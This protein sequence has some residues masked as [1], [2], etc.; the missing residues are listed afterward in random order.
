MKRMIFVILGLVFQ[1][2]LSDVCGAH[3]V[4][5][6]QAERVQPDGTQFIGEEWDSEF[7]FEYETEE[8]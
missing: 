8:T 5:M 1:F 4:Y 2:G 3:E 7:Y 6:P